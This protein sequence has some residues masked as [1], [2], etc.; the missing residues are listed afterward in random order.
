M[1][2]PGENGAGPKGIETGMA[3]S[4]RRAS[5]VMTKSCDAALRI[6]RRCRLRMRLQDYPMPFRFCA[7]SD[8]KQDAVSAPPLVVGG[9]TGIKRR[10]RRLSG[11][12]A[13]VGVLAVLE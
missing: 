10:R 5:S 11:A 4:S 6:D 1:V 7:R 9:T 2:C 8:E 13:A 12:G 3:V